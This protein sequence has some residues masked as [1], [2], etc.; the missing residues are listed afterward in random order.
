MALRADEGRG[1]AAI[2]VGEP[3]AG[4][5]P[6]ISEWGNPLTTGEHRASGGHR[7]N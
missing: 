5:D 1:N 4:C 6:A 7:G 2:C 3:L